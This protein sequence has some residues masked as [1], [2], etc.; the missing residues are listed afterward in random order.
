VCLILL[1]LLAA[2]QVA[3]VHSFD[4]DADHCPLCIVMH[5]AAPVAIAAAIVTLVTMGS[6]APVPQVRAAISPYWHPSL[7]I[8]P[9][10]L[11]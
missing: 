11:G 3:H 2:A 8:R 10:P 4:T 7:F 6:S 1:A 5:S 9:P